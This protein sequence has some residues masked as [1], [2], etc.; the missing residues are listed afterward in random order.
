MRVRRGVA[1]LLAAAVLAA[2]P[3]SAPAGEPEGDG[4]LRA[5]VAAAEG[6]PADRNADGA[7][8]A[9][10]RGALQRGETARGR[11]AAA[12]RLRLRPDDAAAA[13]LLARLCLADGAA[14]EA[15][16]V[17]RAVPSAGA[18]ERA[19]H[20]LL[21]A[22]LEA[23]GRY[24][25]SAAA[26]EDYLARHPGSAAALDA[27]VRLFL[28]SLHDHA[29]AREE[30]ARMRAVAAEPGVPAGTARWL[31]EDADALA[32]ELERLEARARAVREARRS[33]DLRL[34][35]ALAAAAVVLAA[36]FAGARAPRREPEGEPRP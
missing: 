9:Y 26:W 24:A 14:D 19:T 34:G 22:A 4:D 12:H 29:A 18:K 28:W 6:N 7:L 8:E 20:D 1:G 17:L 13:R 27:R 11:R 10:A 31:R 3:A 2:L 25:E 32:A 15:V 35:I 5:L 23:E 16:R 36:A 21:V 30:I 33:L